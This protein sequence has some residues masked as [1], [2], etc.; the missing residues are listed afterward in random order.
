MFSLPAWLHC[1]RAAF[2][3]P[4]ANYFNA[5]SVALK[6]IAIEILSEPAWIRGGEDLKFIFHRARENIRRC[7][8]WRKILFNELHRECKKHRI[9]Q[10][11]EKTHLPLRQGGN[12]YDFSLPIAHSIQS[13]HT[14]LPSV[15][16]S[17]DFFIASASS[18]FYGALSDCHSPPFE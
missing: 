11:Q 6:A 8:I 10:S 16:P 7:I 2:S 13:T 14:R 15:I 18:Y 17:S 1:R 5:R 9:A 3:C 12:F 4:P